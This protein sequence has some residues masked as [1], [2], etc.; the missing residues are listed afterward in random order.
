M[1]VDPGLS[2]NDIAIGDR[3]YRHNVGEVCW[4]VERCYVPPADGIP[5]VALVKEDGTDRV[6]ISLFAL[7]EGHSFKPDRRTQSMASDPGS[8]RRKSDWGPRRIWRRITGAREVT[9]G[10]E[11]NQL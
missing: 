11:A 7:L 6:V 2:M 4:S 1:K 8:K 3:Y 10:A 5:H 9:S